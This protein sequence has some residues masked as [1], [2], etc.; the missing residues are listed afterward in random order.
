MVK[1][2]V[3]GHEIENP[4]LGQPFYPP[5]LLPCVR[6]S[7]YPPSD[8]VAGRSPS[9]AQPTEAELSSCRRLFR[10][11]ALTGESRPHDWGGCCCS[12]ICRVAPRVR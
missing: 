9:A 5:A 10:I 7:S 2:D 1:R 3:Q 11:I 6:E 4:K 12:N 8:L